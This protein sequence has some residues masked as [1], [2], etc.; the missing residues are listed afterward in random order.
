[1]IRYHHTP[2]P[3]GVAPPRQI[4]LPRVPGT[5]L[6]R[7]TALP[8]Q[9]D[10]GN[11][12]VTTAVLQRAA[13]DSARPVPDPTVDQDSAEGYFAAQDAI[14]AFQQQLWTVRNYQLPTGW[15]NF[16]LTYCPV[17]QQV[18]VDIRYAVTFADPADPSVWA[19]HL[20][21]AARA[22]IERSI[23][24]VWGRVVGTFWCQ[25]PWW[26]HLRAELKV[27][28]V[29]DDATPHCRITVYQDGRNSEAY[30]VSQ[31][32]RANETEIHISVG[33]LADR[34][35]RID[36]QTRTAKDVTSELGFPPRIPE[37]AD[38]ED[39]L[40][41]PVVAH[42]F[43]H[44]GPGLPDVY[45][46]REDDGWMRAWHN[47]A[48][49]DDFQQLVQQEMGRK[50][51]RRNDRR[52]MSHGN[53]ATLDD[54]LPFLLALQEATGLDWGERKQPAREAPVCLP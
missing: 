23:Q 25:Q 8:L 27:R 20:K 16:D 12:K 26:E 43:G 52:V 35:F 32:N 42:E 44:A 2:P 24:Q 21:A 51:E 4:G 34:Q 36:P 28:I 33:D 3:L 45:R 1:V 17:S 19:D 47:Q 50:P 30:A 9:R 39:Y 53:V 37:G 11:R 18:R 38:P 5:A 14:R 22:E 40:T 10:V 31:R 15:G 29:E 6:T 41:C 46:G 54:L 48:S 49:F 13:Q 7:A